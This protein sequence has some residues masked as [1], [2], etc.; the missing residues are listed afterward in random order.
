MLRRFLKTNDFRQLLRKSLERQVNLRTIRVA[1]HQPVYVSGDSA[2]IVYFIESGQIKLLMLSPEGKECLLAI[3]TAGDVFGELCLAG[4]NSRL[5]A[6]IAMKETV[7][8]SIPGQ[9]FLDCLDN[10]SLLEGFAQ[11]LAT[12]I[13]E[14]QRII[15][16]ILTVDSEH[17]LGETLLLLARKLG[18]PNI[19]S[20]RIEYK[21]T[22]E[23]LSRMV[24]TTRPRVTHFLGRFRG[25]GLIEMSSDHHLIVN[26][27]KLANYLNA[28]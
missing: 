4:L 8:K 5:E 10:H 28:A 6:A 22:H 20:T 16:T 7:L 27:K 9:V 15:A 21:I 13:S 26:E 19:L 12:R 18:K 2:D 23:D 25:L 24:G 11:H 17:R 1:S 14:Q 3:H